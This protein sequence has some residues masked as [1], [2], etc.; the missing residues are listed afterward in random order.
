MK[1]KEKGFTLVELLVAMLI[2]SLV[3]VAIYKTMDAQQLAY[4]TQQD[5]VEAQQ[6][7]RTGLF[8]MERELRLAGCD[9]TG[10][11][12]A[13][14]VSI[15]TDSFQFT[16]DITGGDRDGI[17]NDLD[18]VD[19]N[20]EEA[21]Y[22]DGA[23]DERENIRYTLVA[24]GNGSN[25]LMREE[26]DNVFGPQPIAENVDALDLV[27]LSPTG[28]ET[29]NPAD[30]S[31]VQITMVVRAPRVERDFKDTNTYTNMQGDTILAAPNDH[32]RRRVLSTQVK[33]RNINI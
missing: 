11:A 25:T 9:A 29:T 20:D 32:H 24:D 27:W 10:S 6:N 5:V 16:T 12:N 26:V 1:N 3:I 33:L 13:G 21:E 31:S 15:G 30:A 18:G 7:L 28:A 17:D 22:F 19:D 8:F 4:V 2:A 14:L 23:I